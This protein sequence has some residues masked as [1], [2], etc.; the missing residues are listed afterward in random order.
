MLGQASR[1]RSARVTPHIVPGM[2]TSVNKHADV[3][4][5]VQD[6]PRLVRLAG[7]DYGEPGFLQHFDG[8]HPDEV[9]V[10]DHQHQRCFG[11][12]LPRHRHPTGDLGNGFRRAVKFRNRGGGRARF[13]YVRRRVA[14][15]KTI[16]RHLAGTVRR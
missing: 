9:I 6:E 10:L 5:L 3:G 1:T 11:V 14:P 2:S 7:F 8:H 12:A 13:R 16:S 4:A 15:S